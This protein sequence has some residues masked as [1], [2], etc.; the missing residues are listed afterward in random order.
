MSE[1]SVEVEESIFE[2]T[3]TSLFF[4]SE[5]FFSSLKFFKNKLYKRIIK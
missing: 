2:D 3:T 4:K 1:K 5:S